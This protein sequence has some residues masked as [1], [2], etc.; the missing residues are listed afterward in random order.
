MADV[1]FVSGD[2]I[3]KDED[4]KWGSVTLLNITI[5][6]TPTT[7][8]VGD[9]VT[10]TVTAHYSDGSSVDVTSLSTLLS[11]NSA[12]VSMGGNVGSCVGVGSCVITATYGIFYA[13]AVVEVVDYTLIWADSGVENLTMTSTKQLLIYAEL[14][15][16][17]TVDVTSLCTFS[18][19]DTNL[20]SVTDGGL[21][22]AWYE[23]Q[24]VVEISMSSLLG[25]TLTTEVTFFIPG[26]LASKSLYPLISECKT[27]TFMGEKMLETQNS[28]LSNSSFTSS[29]W[30][31]P[32]E[33]SGSK[34]SDLDTVKTTWSK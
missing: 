12:L 7:K 23:G 13:L 33:T 28:P 3:F 5:S 11:S 9:T 4:V 10:Y 2:T 30:L 31:L 18:S 27:P 20:L 19:R 32:S 26:L 25:D 34:K 24:V 16:G 17:T 6:P 8:L 14:S 15:N 1:T 22:S 21:C 29:P